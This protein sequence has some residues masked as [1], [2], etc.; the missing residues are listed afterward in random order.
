M[1]AIKI[2]LITLAALIGLF[3]IVGL[4]LPTEMHV[5]KSIEIDTPPN[6]PYMQV[7]N[8]KNMTAWDPWSN[9]DENMET[10]YSGPLFGVENSRE[11]KS[12]DQNVG[13]GKMTVSEAE[14]YKL[15]NTDLDFGDQ[16]L[17]TSY[18]K[19]EKMGEN[20]TKVTWGFD[21]DMDIPIV[22]GYI[23]MAMGGVIEDQYLKGLENLKRVSE[24]VENQRDLTSTQISFEEVESQKVICISGATTQDDES[25][26]ALF[27]QN[28]GQLMSN[29][30]VNQMEMAGAP[31]TVN[32][33]WED[34]QYE[35][36]NCI[37]VKEVKGDLSAS[38]LA[39]DTYAG[40]TVKIIHTGSYDGMDK[41][42]EDV[43]AFIEQSNFEIVGNPWEVYISDPGNTPEDKLIT[44]IYF[45]IK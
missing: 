37:P 19:F 1:K 22:G 42:Y 18:F 13:V 5:E 17:A 41:T 33:K 25:I 43:M 3:I 23:V 7:A 11:W 4:F 14:P 6:V 31:M 12:I 29:V 34:N 35:F 45:P 28:Y 32:T 9:I 30:Q 16:G 21:S 8:L 20:K 10:S 15:I 40:P 27:G 39:K 24:A 26:S 36:M 2:I 44:H 38:V